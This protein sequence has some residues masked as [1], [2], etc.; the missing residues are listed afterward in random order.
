MSHLRGLGLK[1]PLVGGILGF[2]GV[3]GYFRLRP[4]R[5]RPTASQLMTMDS[6]TF[7]SFIRGTG[8]RTLSNREPNTSGGSGD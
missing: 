8:I 5:K 2:G 1:W 6:A 3:L 4:K 7:E